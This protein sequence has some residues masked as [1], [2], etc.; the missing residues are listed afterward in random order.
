MAWEGGNVSDIVAFLRARLDEDEAAARA[1]AEQ[2]AASPDSSAEIGLAH[3]DLAIGD[4]PSYL[5]D[6]DPARVRADVE[7][8]RRIVAEHVCPCPDPD[9]G[10]CSACSGR[11]HAD[12]TPA[13]CTTL[14]MLALPFADHPDY[15]EA[16]KVE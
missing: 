13:P 10:D 11:H 5:G 8:K 4:C 6:Y 15:D 16:W 1:I 2:V 14:R 9:C 12:P 7:A 3:P